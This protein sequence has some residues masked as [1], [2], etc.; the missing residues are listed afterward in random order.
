[1]YYKQQEQQKMRICEGKN[2]TGGKY[3]GGVPAEGEDGRRKRGGRERKGGEAI[4][5]IAMERRS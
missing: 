5:M 2:L 3:E 1:M 4:R